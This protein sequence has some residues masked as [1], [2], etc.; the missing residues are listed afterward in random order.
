MPHGAVGFVSRRLQSLNWY[1]GFVHRL[2][3]PC[4]ARGKSASAEPTNGLGWGAL[5]QFEATW[6]TC[7]GK[8]EPWSDFETAQNSN[9]TLISGDE[10]H[11]PGA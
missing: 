1:W 6:D 7:S 2:V 4:T 10:N 8:Q 9:V 5:R 3:A 11:S